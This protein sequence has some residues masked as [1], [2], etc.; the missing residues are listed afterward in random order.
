MEKT[1]AL[2]ETA[3]KTIIR[4]V[5]C[6]RIDIPRPMLCQRDMSPRD[7][8]PMR[9]GRIMTMRRSKTRSVAGKSIFLAKDMSRMIGRHKTLETTEQTVKISAREVFPPEK[10]VQIIEEER[11]VGEELR[12]IIPAKS[13][14]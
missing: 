2:P 13:K 12:I 1:G 10:R 11:V 5:P 6:P 8:C 9:E 7:S 14:G 4:M 3:V